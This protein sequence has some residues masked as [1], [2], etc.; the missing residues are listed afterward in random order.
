MAKMVIRI[1]QKKL[2]NLKEKTQKI[3]ARL[4]KKS[5]VQ[6]KRELRHY[7]SNV[8]VHLEKF[9]RIDILPEKISHLEKAKEGLRKCLEIRPGHRS[10][11]QQLRL[12]DELSLQDREE[13]IEIVLDRAW[14]P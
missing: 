14:L 13:K 12:C 4:S 10:F 6:V 9:N 1:P 5:K 11:K 8:L 7:Y 2:V 3:L